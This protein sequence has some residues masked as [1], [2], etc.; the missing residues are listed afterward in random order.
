M[1]LQICQELYEVDFV[2][3][4]A[5]R[6]QNLEQFVVRL[7]NQILPCQEGPQLFPVQPFL[8]RLE[9][10]TRLKWTDVLFQLLKPFAL[11]FVHQEKLV[12]NFIHLIL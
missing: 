12:I 6:R 7:I 11:L 4:L 9:F 8:G 3:S 10:R 5:L 1:L 2:E